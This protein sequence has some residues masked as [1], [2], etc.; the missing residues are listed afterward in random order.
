VG[1]AYG[2][3]AV[4][5]GE[6]RPRARRRCHPT[7]PY[8]PGIDQQRTKQ[9]VVGRLQL[10]QVA[11]GKVSRANPTESKDGHVV[12]ARAT[13]HLAADDAGK[14]GHRSRHLL[15]SSTRDLA[16]YSTTAAGVR[17][18]RMSVQSGL[19]GAVSPTAFRC[20]PGRSSLGVRMVAQR[21]S[22]VNGGHDVR[23]L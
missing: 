10:V 17:L 15:Y 21:L 23:A 2:F 20:M 7:N 9:A 11:Q 19:A 3:K 13:G 8:R 12:G 16:S 5:A 18:C 14:L 1:H 22:A 6:K 4:R